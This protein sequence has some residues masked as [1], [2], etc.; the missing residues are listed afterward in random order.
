MKTFF[1]KNCIFFI[2]MSAVLILLMVLGTFKDYQISTLLVGH[3][4]DGGK[5]QATN[6]FA[7]I[8]E[9]IGVLPLYIFVTFGCNVLFIKYFHQD[10]RIIVRIIGIIF[11]ILGVL[12]LMYGFKGV[13][14]YIADQFS[15]GNVY[16]EKNSLFSSSLIKYLVLFVIS[17]PL[18]FVIYLFTKKKLNKYIDNLVIFAYIIIG[19]LLI[20]QGIIQL[21]IKPYM[22]RARYRTINYLSY[23]GNGTP[24]FTRW[25]VSAGKTKDFA[26]FYNVPKDYFKSFPSGH[27]SGAGITFTLFCLPAIFTMKR[28]DIVMM[29]TIAIIIP[30]VVA[31]TRVM[32]GA[33]FT[34]D[35][36]MGMII[37]FISSLISSIICL[38]LFKVDKKQIKE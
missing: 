33:H 31:I 5:Y 26:M 7:Q 18:S 29:Y 9:V 38:L 30:V 35:V 4:L 34:S 21:V 17:A 23:L 13:D 11:A 19:T 10:K 32:M 15:H 24:D 28:K 20:S 25:Y 3:S 1:K 36:T 22:G 37:V 2:V 14:E 16:G 8:F 6:F 12:S 27:T